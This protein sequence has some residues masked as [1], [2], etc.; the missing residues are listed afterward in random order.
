MSIL[1]ALALSAAVQP[2]QTCLANAPAVGADPIAAF[3]KAVDGSTIKD[4]RQLAR[5]R[6]NSGDALIVVRG[7]D[8]SGQKV[9]KAKLSNICFVDTKL[10]RTDWR[11]AAAPGFGFIR[12]DLSGATLAGAQLS[13]V[14]LRESSLAAVDATGADMTGGRLDGGWGGSMAGLRL[15]GAR[16]VN[17]QVRCG[18]REVDGCPFDRANMSIRGA[19][20]TGANLATFSFWN[21]ALEGAILANT[22]VGVQQIGQ[23]TSLVVKGPIIIHSPRRRV[24][25]FPDDYMAVRAGVKLLNPALQTR[26]AAKPVD[27]ESC[28]AIVDRRDHALCLGGP[29]LQRAAEMA[30]AAARSPT[31]AVQLAS[32]TDFCVNL[33]DDMIPSCLARAYRATIELQMAAAAAASPSGQLSG[34]AIF[35]SLPMRFDDGFRRSG[36]YTRMLPVLLDVAPT[37]IFALVAGDGR[38]TVRGG[39]QNGCRISADNLVWLPQQG[40]YGTMPTTLQRMRRRLIVARQAPVLRFGPTGIEFAAD[41]RISALSCAPGGKIDPVLR[42]DGPSAFISLIAEQWQQASAPVSMPAAT[43]AVTGA[44]TGAATSSGAAAVPR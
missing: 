35:A 10:A 32:A 3:P 19:D 5:L 24:T 7:G 26:E 38:L 39:S 34:S 12:A 18:T 37:Q 14:L 6:K 21:T 2:T 42:I 15:D 22:H 13:Q 27:P 28:A 43:G 29:E 17:F 25:L 44:A 30:T 36:L 33:S 23:L 9:G 11:G 41:A 31:A 8:F 16:L 1:Y 20:F 40:W 4:F